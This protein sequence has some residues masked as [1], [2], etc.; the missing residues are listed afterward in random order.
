MIRFYLTYLSLLLIST[1][2]YAQNNYYW[3][4]QQGPNGNLLGGSLASGASDNSAIFYNPGALAFTETPNVSLTSDLIS[5]TF[6]HIQNGAGEGIDIKGNQLTTK[7]QMLAGTA[8]GAKNN[9]FKV[10][11]AIFNLLNEKSEHSAQNTAQISNSNQVYEGFYNYKNSLRN[12]RFA[13]GTT[14]RLTDNIGIG[15]THF[16][17]IKS[18]EI[19]SNVNESWY[20]NKLATNYSTDFKNLKYSH[21][22]LLWKLGIAWHYNEKLNLGLNFET[23][24]IRIKFLSTA[25]SR[26]IS[27]TLDDNGVLQKY[28]SNQ[29]KVN[30]SYSLPFTFDLNLG[31]TT[32]LT[33]YSARVGFFSKV[34]KYNLLQLKTESTINPSPDPAYNQYTLSNKRIINYA[35]GVKHRILNDMNI[36][37]GFRTD[38]NFI[39]QEDINFT[40]DNFL[41]FN[42]WDVYHLSSGVEWFGSNFN[43]IAG[44]VADFGFSE[45]NPQLVNL[46]ARPYSELNDFNTNT[47]TSYL[48]LNLIFGITYHFKDR[49]QM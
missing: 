11:Y 5:Y 35:A 32:K 42:Y 34:G 12:D 28:S 40:K 3:S 4:Q 43:I 21:V 39:N 19:T 38:F 36:L 41:S 14:Y 26:R 2:A 9:R 15:I 45:N 31:Y 22:S 44:I 29:D 13:I 17:D 25:Y 30:T 20:T 33:Q 24:D 47:E 27:E 37:M 6:L 23:P 48:Q 49:T 8:F 1:T 7:P 18:T 10:T 16:V 46:T